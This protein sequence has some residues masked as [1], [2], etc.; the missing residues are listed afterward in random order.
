MAWS[1]FLDPIFN[2]LLNI[3]PALA[4]FIVSFIITFL[5]TIVYK[6]TTD[7]KRMK[8]LKD[9][10]KDAQDKMKSLAKTNPE[11]AMSM[12]SSMMQKNLE[13][14]K[15]SFKATLYTLIPVLII[16]SW[17]SL[18]MAY[19]PIH[20]GQQFTVTAEFS[21]GHASN[22]TLT[23]IPD[24]SFASDHTQMITYDEAS[25][26][27]L[28]VWKLSGNTGEYQLD[29]DYNNEKY[30]HNV[31]IADKKYSAPEKI[32]TDSK[33]KKITIGNEKIYPFNIFGLKITWFW[34]YLIMS[35]ALSLGIRKI[36]KVY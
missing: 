28:A 4:I 23:S 6:Y 7:Q 18:H 19:Y 11:K 2:P 5:V 33:L 30:S 21:Q 35:I 14:M 22:A 32:V 17:M 29:L 13:Y 34:T 9:E 10:L 26:K 15:H 20:A 12:Q 24:L 36:M 1:D 8:Q 16:F 31:L 3:H 27:E 25:K